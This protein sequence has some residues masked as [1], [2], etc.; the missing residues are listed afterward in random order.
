MTSSR[1]QF[2]RDVWDELTGR[3]EHRRIGQRAVEQT[4]EVVTQTILQETACT[5]RRRHLLTS[6]HPS[7]EYEQGFCDAV[8]WITE[9]LDP[10][11][12]RNEERSADVAS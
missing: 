8:K 3:A 5:I 11:Q 6:P 1:R 12:K 7:H 4:L 10:E 9:M 2:V